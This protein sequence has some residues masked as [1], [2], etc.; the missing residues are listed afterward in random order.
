MSKTPDCKCG[1]N[2]W[3]PMPD[4]LALACLGKDG[5]PGCGRV[6]VANLDGTYEKGASI[7]KWLSDINP[8]LPPLTDPDD[9]EQ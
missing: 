7:Q 8:H 3:T 6:I 9:E 5:E 2:D 4:S 1:R